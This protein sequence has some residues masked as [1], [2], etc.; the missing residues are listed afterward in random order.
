MSS[1]EER[2]AHLLAALKHAPDAQLQAPPGLS[3]QIL[4]R[5]RQTVAPPPRPSAWQ[6]LWQGFS[7]PTRWGASGAFATLVLAGF[8]T[9]LWQ[10]DRPG[11]A[12]EERG[13]TAEAPAPVAAPAPAPTAPATVLA[14]AAAPAAKPAAPSLAQDKQD[15]L[16]TLKAPPTPA[17]ERQRELARVARA[18]AEPTMPRPRVAAAADAADAAD[19]AVSTA[20]TVAAA[21]PPAAARTQAAPA[22]K[23]QSNSGLA[24]AAATPSAES[25]SQTRVAPPPWGGTPVAADGFQWQPAGTAV[26]ARR[27]LAQLALLTAG[28][29]QAAPDA[30]P[31]AGTP[32]LQG[33]GAGAQASRWW[34][35]RREAAWWVLWCGA[36][37][38]GCQQAPLVGE[39]PAGTLLPVQ[40]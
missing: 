2:D 13:A 29:W 23:A 35:E 5:A 6:R 8:V 32:V 9:L 39:P 22:F 7:T 21:P 17:S 16:K 38:R 34:F 3:A 26:D 18:E 10:Q 14:E 36:Q 19:A 28:Q 15:T 40:R 1:N 11:P 25:M 33:P 31:A 4:A 20:P 37:G 12:T 30:Q 27:L 24:G